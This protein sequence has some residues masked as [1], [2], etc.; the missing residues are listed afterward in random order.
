VIRLL[1]E[2]GARPTSLHDVVEH[3]GPS[4]VEA[5][6]VAGGAGIVEGEEDFTPL[7]VAVGRREPDMDVIEV[8][9]AGLCMGPKRVAL[10]MGRCSSATAPTPRGASS[11]ITPSGPCA[12][13]SRL[14]QT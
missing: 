3:Y 2:R 4:L 5:F 12:P 13:S 14:A 1:L 7:M 11:C 8:R 9:S 6:I 10:C